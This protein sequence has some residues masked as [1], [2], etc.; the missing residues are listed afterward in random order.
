MA[1]RMMARKMYTGYI[2]NSHGL[3]FRGEKCPPWDGLTSAVRSH[4]CAAAL[5]AMPQLN[6]P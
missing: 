1:T 3:N 5:V 2:E 4:W 6:N